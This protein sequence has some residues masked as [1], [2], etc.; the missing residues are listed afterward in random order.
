VRLGL[1]WDLDRFEDAGAGWQEVVAEAEAADRMGF[2]SF[3]IRE[4]REGAADCP[5]PSIFLTYLAKKTK[6]AQLRIAGRRV[7]RALPAHIAEEVAVLDTFS[8]GRA[9]LGF[10]PASAQGVAPGHVHEMIEFVTSA[11]TA[12]E[13]RYRGEHIRFPAHTPDDAPP[14]ASTP[15][16]KG[17]YLPQWEWGEDTPD[18]LSITPKPYV[19]H[20]PVN[21][22]IDDDETLEW[23]AR[24]GISPMVGAD[25]PTAE[26]SRRLAHYRE[27]A[28]EAGRAPREVEAVL[29]R[30]IALDAEGD[31]TTLGGSPRDLLNA[32]R[33]LR[34]RTAI[35]HFVWRRNGATPMDLY[36]FA[37]EVQLLLQA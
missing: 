21:V 14:G 6:S 15:E 30:R 3:W 28:N 32:I 22:E 17:A 35:S 23:A 13:I 20:T 19:P 2:Q 11:W 37:S 33:E 26:A 10:A 34:G 7:T 36:R 24:N 16:A 29:E 25:M 12:D 27:V 18:F 8:R 9:G 4:G 31:E 5:E 1:S